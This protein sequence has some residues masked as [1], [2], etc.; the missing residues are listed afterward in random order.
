M[1]NTIKK[2]KSDLGQERGPP[3]LMRTIGQLPDREVAD[4]IKT[5]DFSTLD[6]A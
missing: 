4:L 2:A 6:G 1:K 5:V 3:S